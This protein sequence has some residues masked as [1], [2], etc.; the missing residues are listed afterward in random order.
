LTQACVCEVSNVKSAAWV[1]WTCG[2]DECCTDLQACMVVNH[3]SQLPLLL[4]SSD[5]HSSQPLYFLFFF[6][7]FP[8]PL[9]F[10]IFSKMFFK[11]LL[12]LFLIA[13]ACVS[14]T[15][16]Q[17]SISLKHTGRRNVTAAVAGQ[18]IPLSG[19]IIHLG[20]YYVDITIGGTQFAVQLDSGSSTLAVA[21]TTCSGCGSGLATLSPTSAGFSA[22]PCGGSCSSCYAS[23]GQCGF[24]VGYGDGS[25]ISGPLAYDTIQI[26]GYSTST[27]A[28]GLMQQASGDFSSGTT[29]IFGVAYANLNCN[30][31]CNPTV[32]DKIVQ[33]S[34]IPY[35]FGVCLNTDGGVW[36]LGFADPNKASGGSIQYTP[37]TRAGYYQVTLN[38]LGVSGTSLSYAASSDTTIVDSGTTLLL[39]SQSAFSAVQSQLL[40]MN[41]PQGSTLFA[42]ALSCAFVSDISSF[43]SLTFSFQNSVTVTLP[44]SAYL[45]NMGGTQYCFGIDT[46]GSGMSILG[47]VFMQNFYVVFDQQNSRVGFANLQPGSCV[48]SSSSVTYSWAAGSFGACSTNCGNGTQSRSV[49]CQSSAGGTVANSFCNPS[50]EPALNQPCTSSTGCVTYGWNSGS[51][52]VC[53]STQC[54]TNGTQTRPVTCTG[55]DGKA[56]P[57]TNCA[58]TAPSSSQGCAAAPCAMTYAWQSG[59]WSS[60]SATQCGTT[61]TQT[62]TITCIGSDGHTYPATNCGGTAPASS[63]PCSAAACPAITYSWHLGNWSSCSATQCG[64]TGTQTR[65]VTCVGSDGQTYTATNCG[66]PPSASQSCSA[67]ACPSV[68]YSWQL[69]N[70]SSCSAT[71]CGTTGTQTRSVTCVGSDGQTYPATN[72]GTTPSASQSCSAAACP[73]ITYSWQSGSWSSCSAT[74]CGTNGTQTR[75]VTCQGSDGQTYPASNCASSGATPASSQ[76]CSATGCSLVYFWQTSPWSACSATVCGTNGVQSRSVV[77]VGS[78][79]H[80][81]PASSCSSS[82]TQPPNTQSCAAPACP[83]S[84][85]WS[86]GTWSACSATQCGTNGTQTR[87]VTCVGSSGIIAPLSNCAN[88]GP[89]PAISQP[90]SAPPCAP[91]SYSWH[92]TAW[93]A[94]S[95]TVCGANG[96]QSRTVFCADSNGNIAPTSDCNSATQPSSTQHCVGT[97]CPPTQPQFSWETGSWSSC[98]AIQCGTQG[99]QTRSVL[100]V[101]SNGLFYPYASCANQPMPA[102]I[103]SCSASCTSSG[104]AT[105]FWAVSNWG[106]CVMN[107]PAGGLTHRSVACVQETVF[108]LQFVAAALCPQPAPASVANCGSC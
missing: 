82:G 5:Q 91:T 104:S 81:Y 107:C 3:Y 94:C 38:T 55:S 22:I 66:T 74:Q 60:C 86:S 62:R 19:S 39:L 96:T 57:A 68:T 21:S 102:S 63:Q 71:Q 12:T 67:A 42:Q 28:F 90:C 29:G 54:G 59:S 79:Q 103:Q 23:S 89:E 76:P 61:G 52:S 78:D 14:S 73:S 93:S 31:N 33:Q 101:G 95:T 6:S 58:G 64:T 46:T 13:S 51:W 20:E 106:M 77:C 40:S 69:G 9:T 27:A 45:L 35:V 85:S 56:Y 32:L 72:C 18:T 26:G 99:Q 4:V 25:R 10:S 7:F 44:P 24:T 65:S 41:L 84:Y 97:Y 98:S 30:P 53:S 17:S 8:S 36:D 16:A 80:I 15:Y 87:L 92:T 48:A 37:I 100:C 34:G 11:R 88:S 50:T 75:S 47:D 105:Y 1:L 83:T 108:G 70:W 2:R 49:T 43:P